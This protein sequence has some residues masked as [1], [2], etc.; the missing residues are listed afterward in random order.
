MIRRAVDSAVPAENALRFP[1]PLG[2]PFGYPTDTTAPTKTGYSCC[3]P[4][5]GRSSV[6]LSVFVPSCLRFPPSKRPRVLHPRDELSAS[7]SGRSRLQEKVGL[8]PWLT[9]MSF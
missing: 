2:I 4:N 3:P 1:Q 7:P 8:I 5:R 9:A 6:V